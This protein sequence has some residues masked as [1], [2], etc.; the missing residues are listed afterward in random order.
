L[1]YRDRKGQDNYLNN[2]CYILAEF[3]LLSLYLLLC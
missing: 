1:I 3:D 2:L